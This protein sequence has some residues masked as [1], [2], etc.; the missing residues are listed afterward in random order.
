MAEYKV[1]IPIDVL[2][3]PRASEVTAAKLLAIHSGSDVY[4]VARSNHKTPD[5]KVGNTYWELKS[6]TGNGKRTIQ[7]ALQAA[8]HQSPNIVIDARQSKMHIVKM[9]HELQWQ[10]THTKK[11]KRLLLIT[12]SSTI[13]EIQRTK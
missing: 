1:I 8:L 9:K 10:F 13:I 5:F 2:P 4:F 6:P 7:H 11:I 12:K 3:Y